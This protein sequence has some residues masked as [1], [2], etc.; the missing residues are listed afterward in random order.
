MRVAAKGLRHN[1]LELQFDLERILARG[2]AGA[3]AHTKD[4]RVDREGFLTESGVEHDVRR[5]PSDTRQLLELFAGS[6]NLA[7]MIADQGF[8]QG[9][10]VL[11][12]GVEKADGLDR[13]A[14]PLLT[15]FH[16]LFRRADV[17]EDRTAGDI[18]ADVG[19]LGGQH[20]CN[21]QGVRIGVFQLRGR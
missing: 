18:D 19:R 14:Q 10:D 17:L 8:G 16:H 9:D 21:Q 7:G 13:V 6:R 20:D 15:E 1:F 4:V 3:V 12:L 5:L 2:E 11:R